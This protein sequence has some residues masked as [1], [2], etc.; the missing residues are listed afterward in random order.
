M[1]IDL[2]A[3][4]LCEADFEL[5]VV[6]EGETIGEVIER[7]AASSGRPL[8]ALAIEDAEEDL[9]V[10]A[11]AEDVLQPR[12][13]VHFHRRHLVAV[14]VE[15]AGRTPIMHSFRPNKRAKRVYDWAVGKDGFDFNPVDAAELVLATGS[16]PSSWKRVEVDSHIGDIAGP[17]DRVKLWLVPKSFFQG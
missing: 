4:G 1:P 2:R 7:F 3:H 13:H 11:L 14:T 10:A 6:G 17:D 12:R 8:I 16:P 5:I 15:Y 9:D